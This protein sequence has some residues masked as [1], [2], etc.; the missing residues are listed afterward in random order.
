MS[1]MQLD[2]D[3]FRLD[4]L[5]SHVLTGCVLAQ[6]AISDD[7]ASS[8]PKGPSPRHYPSLEGLVLSPGA[9]F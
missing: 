2:R 7:W 3:T 6:V 9:P 5:A 1:I 8:S 4:V